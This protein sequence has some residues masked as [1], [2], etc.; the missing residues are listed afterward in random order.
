MQNMPGGKLT[1][2]TLRKPSAVPNSWLEELPESARLHFV[3]LELKSQEFAMSYVSAEEVM[4][5]M[6]A[7]DLSEAELEAVVR[8][9]KKHYDLSMIELRQAKLPGNNAV[10]KPAQAPR[11]QRGSSSRIRT[12]EP[13]VV[14][15]GH[16]HG[17]VT[18]KRPKLTAVSLAT[19][20]QQ[21]YDDIVD[22]LRRV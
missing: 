20:S 10:S 9:W 21:T 16:R 7:L 3:A 18:R 13:V 8:C 4:D 6:D 11:Q 19:L 12:F 17:M 14:K 22:I 1:V 15:D 2:R 5:D